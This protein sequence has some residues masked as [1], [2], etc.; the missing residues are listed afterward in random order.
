MNRNGLLLL[1]L[2]AGCAGNRPPARV[3]GTDK[4]PLVSTIRR[5]NQYR[6][7]ERQQLGLGMI[8]IAVRSVDEPT[9]NLE[10]AQIELRS[11]TDSVLAQKSVR[12]GGTL[13]LDSVQAGTYLVTAKRIGYLT[14]RLPAVIVEAG[15]RL[16]IEAYLAVSPIYVDPDPAPTTRP[17]TPARAIITYCGRLH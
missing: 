8:E 13:M 12:K 2:I 16:E 6:E 10:G 17:R 4:L 11:S 3:A 7:R 15:C 1:G 5:S 14:L 9:L